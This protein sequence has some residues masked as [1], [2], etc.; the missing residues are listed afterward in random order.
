MNTLYLLGLCAVVGA[1][2]SLY[3]LV[4]MVRRN[5]AQRE[6]ARELDE[7]KAIVDGR[8]G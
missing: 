7:V 5:K 3:A 1:L 4:E 8:R 2:L 6:F